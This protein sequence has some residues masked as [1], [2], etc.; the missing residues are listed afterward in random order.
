MREGEVMIRSRNVKLR[1]GVK[2]KKRNGKRSGEK[3]TQ[4]KRK[5]NGLINGQLISIVDIREVKT[6][7]M[8]LMIIYSPS[9]IG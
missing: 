4:D 9:I 5:K 6:G 2:M 1:S 8:N 7:V 3:F